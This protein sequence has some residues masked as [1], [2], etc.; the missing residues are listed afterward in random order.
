MELPKLYS[1]KPW[2][3]KQLLIKKIVDSL[4]RLNPDRF[5][6]VCMQLENDNS[7]VELIDTIILNVYSDMGVYSIKDAISTLEVTLND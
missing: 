6:N 5:P 2:H 4:A 1:I 3:R 7:K